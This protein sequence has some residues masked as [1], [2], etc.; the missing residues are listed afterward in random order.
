MVV[1]QDLPNE[2]VEQI[3]LKGCEDNLGGPYDHPRQLKSFAKL[4]AGVCRSWSQIIRHPSAFPETHFWTTQLRLYLDRRVS[5]SWLVRDLVQ[6][7]KAL[8]KTRGCDVIVTFETDIRNADLDHLSPADAMKLLLFLHGMHA[9]IPYQRQIVAL[10]MTSDQPQAIAHYWR[11]IST[12]IRTAPRLVEMSLATLLGFPQFPRYDSQE[13]PNFRPILQQESSN[14]GVAA[15]LAHLANVDTLSLSDLSWLE[16]PRHVT[17]AT[18]FKLSWI[19]SMDGLFGAFRQREDI[20]STLVSLEL[21]RVGGPPG[22]NQVGSTSEGN[23]QEEPSPGHQSVVFER[24]RNLYL[25]IDDISAIEFIGKAEYPSI[26]VMRSRLICHYAEPASSSNQKLAAHSDFASNTSP[27]RKL[28]TLETRI[29]SSWNSLDYLIRLSN[30]YDVE[31]LFLKEPETEMP[32]SE[33]PIFISR[34]HEVLSIFKPVSLSVHHSTYPG[35]FELLIRLD[36][37]RVESFVLDTSHSSNY[38]VS[39]EDLRNSIDYLTRGSVLFMPNLRTLR[40]S[41]ASWQEMSLHEHMLS[42]LQA[43]NLATIVAEMDHPSMPSMTPSVSQTSSARSEGF[44]HIFSSVQRLDYTLD[45]WSVA[46]HQCLRR[47]WEQVPGA[48]ELHLDVYG[49]S[50]SPEVELKQASESGMS[51]SLMNSSDLGELRGLECLFDL[52]G[53]SGEGSALLSKLR[54][55]VVVFDIRPYYPETYNHD[56]MLQHLQAELARLCEGRAKLGAADLTLQGAI[57]YELQPN[58]QLTDTLRARVHIHLGSRSQED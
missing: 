46:D 40:Q 2:V 36:L 3:F 50:S 53:P 19:R 41:L 4:V 17:T 49:L 16:D 23:Q 57:T 54:T 51:L 13:A 5:S 52:L 7:Q 18:K 35:A 27:R 34:I 26:E 47:I 58:V 14:S 8:S 12:H 38:I 43:P 15:S 45:A 1:V 39:N 28:F 6:F 11:L 21:H 9:I 25:A 29:P 10:R 42:H 24:L 31:Q 33:H 37:N 55:I 56:H 48:G 30:A 22:T 32:P 44:E 20:T